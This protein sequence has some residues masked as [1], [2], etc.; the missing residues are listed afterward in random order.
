MRLRTKVLCVL[1]GVMLLATLASFAIQY[2]VIYPSFV[3]LERKE[4]VKDWQ[5]CRLAIDREVEHL[6]TLNL[7]WGSWDDTYRFA[8]GEFPEY[9]KQNIGTSEWFSDQKLDVFFICKPDGTVVFGQVLDLQT[10]EPTTLAWFPVER[11][12]ADHPLL[13]VQPTKESCISGLVMTER[14]LMM[15][16]SRPI[17]TSE[18]T[19]PMAGVLIFGRLITP[20]YTLSLQDQTQVHFQIWSV[21]GADIPEDVKHSVQAA[22]QSPDPV[23]DSQQAGVLKVMGM[24]PDLNGNSIAVINADVL[25]SISAKGRQ[26]IQFASI[27]MVVAGMLT[28]V[29]LMASLGYIVLRPL[30]KLTDHAQEISGSGDMS[31]RMVV[32]RGDELGVLAG[33]FNRMLEKIEEYRT[34]SMAMSRQAGMAEITTGVLHNV[35][36]A[37]TNTGILAESLA[38]KVAASKVPTLSRAVALIREHQNELPRYLTED[39][40]GQQLPNFLGQLADHLN[41][42]MTQTQQD[43]AALCEGVKHVKEIVATQQKFAKGSNVAEPLELYPLLTQAMTLVNGSMKKHHIEV[44]IEAPYK[45]TVLCDRSKLQ[46]VLVNLLTN[47]KDA[48]RD[49]HGPDNRDPHRIQVLLTSEQ[50]QAS[51]KITDCGM[52]I[53][54][55]NLSKIFNNGFTTKA[56]GHGFGLHY[57]ALAVKEM[58]GQLRVTSPGPG[59]GATFQICLPLATSLVSETTV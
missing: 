33:Q 10:M 13:Q 1:T 32:D 22:M 37:M 59:Q 56:T 47:A 48:I 18:N 55:E 50:G 30:S 20:D 7:D 6:A 45:P 23:V 9:Y 53:A 12:P 4:A 34:Q 44:V 28:L 40:K 38:E 11:L 26:A 24:L 29:T 5:R 36:N 39:A 49:H 27:S 46:Q 17:L 35:G 42:E 43:I 15:V 51:I 3:A 57:S 41:R 2:L 8:N 21:D 25:P 58:S 52:G 14:G 54:P 16:S 31:K 19:G